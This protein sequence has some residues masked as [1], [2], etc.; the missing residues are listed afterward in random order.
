MGQVL[1][2]PADVRTHEPQSRQ[3]VPDT[4]RLVPVAPVKRIQVTVRAALGTMRRR[5]LWVLLAVFASLVMLSLVMR[6]STNPGK[7]TV[8]F[9][10]DS[11][12]TQLMS[13]VQGGKIK[14]VT[15][16]SRDNVAL[17][18]YRDKHDVV[19]AV[20]EAMAEQLQR[21]IVDAH[22]DLV[23]GTGSARATS[24]VVA[25]GS[26]HSQLPD[27]LI[28]IGVIGLVVTGF[29]AM[30]LHGNRSSGGY[31]A[32]GG[33]PRSGGAH[34]GA[35]KKQA[36]QVEEALEI[37]T[38][39]SD[40]A[41][42]EEAVA[43]LQEM[44]E[45]L[46]D[47]SRFTRLGAKP[48]A[49]A[50]LCGPPGTGKTLLARAVA[51]EAGVPFLSASGSD[52]VEK[53]VGVGASRIRALFEQARTHEAAIVFFD[54]L[55]A[56]ARRRSD[57]SESVANSETENTLI[58]L[59]TELD[60]F[61]DRG[62]VIVLAATNREDILD[63]AVIRPGRLDRKIQIPNPDRRGREQI[64]AVHAAGRPLADDVDLTGV[65]RRTPG[66][67]GAQLEAIVNEACM[68]A[69]RDDRS[70]VTQECF[71]FA[72]ATVAMGRARTSALVPEHDR[73]VTA[74]HEAGHTLAALLIPEADDPVQVTII[75]R[76][77]AGGVTWMGGSDNI[78]LARRKA[79]AQLV[80]AMAGRAA[81]EALLGGEFTS[82]AS[83]D[84]QSATRTATA[85]VAHYGMSHVG[86]ALRDPKSSEV[87]AE[88]ERL[89]RDA[90]DRAVS[91]LTAH[92]ALLEL[93]ATELLEHETL[94]FADITAL[95]H[96]LGVDVA[97]GV[98]LPE[99]PVA[100]NPA[101]RPEQEPAGPVT[102]FRPVPV[103]QLAG[104]RTRRLLPRSAITTWV[105]RS[106]S[107]PTASA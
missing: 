64:L 4:R 3:L 57:G 72:V 62:N 48:P 45:F 82:G 73:E 10:K 51:G 9:T 83:G 8:T 70:E 34:G 61:A 44:V 78:F 84:L 14:S 81:E 80:V 90:H 59:L 106:G 103:D 53:Y 47:P 63:P 101:P 33:H 6:F 86:Y 26:G 1:T 41:G 15:Y 39:F 36:S 28:I 98:E 89:L 100:V 107:T 30:V 38:R 16:F 23:A 27:I 49:G 32:S 31:P 21:D 13:D 29:G 12:V 85:M 58:S 69:A 102:R 105:R 79:H 74:W 88:V 68:V 92:H 19:V 52:F 50:L 91:L 87:V 97:A 18:A 96:R 17:A 5:P 22:V 11:S 65:A 43:D 35:R 67:S 25:H 71:D 55:D 7:P 95:A 76:G 20:P 40:V 93:V 42:C 66:F 37:P 54:E 94:T 46:K 2:A 60:G 24:E 56:F 104:R 77:P 99:V 75:P